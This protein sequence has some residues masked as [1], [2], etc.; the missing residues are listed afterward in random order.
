MARKLSFEWCE[1][2]DLLA[3]DILLE[4]PRVIPAS[5]NAAMAHLDKDGFIDL[6]SLDVQDRSATVW[7]GEE[8]GGWRESEEFRFPED[9]SPQHLEFADLNGDSLLDLLIVGTSEMRVFMNS[10][11]SGF[12]LVSETLPA[13][14]LMTL[15]DFNGD[16]HTDVA[17]LA[18]GGP[19]FNRGEFTTQGISHQAIVFF[20][21]GDGTFT[22]S[23]AY[24][25]GGIRNSVTSGD[26]DG[27]GDVDLFVVNANSDRDL[28]VLHN[29][30]DGTFKGTRNE[31]ML[32]GRQQ[33]GD[34]PNMIV[35][36][37]F[38]S[39]GHLDVALAVEWGGGGSASTTLVTHT[40]GSFSW[41]A[42]CTASE[43]S[44]PSKGPLVVVLLNDGQGGYPKADSYRIGD[45]QPDSLAAN[46]LNGDGHLDLV[47]EV[48][49]SSGHDYVSLLTGNGDGSFEM[50]EQIDLPMHTARRM[51]VA[52]A[53]ADGRLEVAISG[54]L[55][56]HES[57]TGETINGIWVY[58]N[59]TPLTGD[60]NQDGI[61]NFSDFL[62][63]ANNFGRREASYNDGDTNGDGKVSFVDFVLLAQN[64]GRHW[65]IG[66]LS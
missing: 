44:E 26:V 43:C 14:R 41:W 61:V 66:P 64:F 18:H 52:D 4:G 17:L 34:D 28:V 23:D 6:V 37:D 12:Q 62:I 31:Y 21:E 57:P 15:N 8:K 65:Q 20:G 10:E 51:T 30:G 13:S 7:R 1:A 53:N 33:H 63:L 55:Y 60:L 42:A 11:S 22:R 47:A 3:A 39:D 56:G 19:K 27:D 45:G 36:G 59:V 5:N 38:N 9:S 49:N 48:S 50:Q 2:R 40:S 24:A 35:V 25:T 32:P 58:E 54:V 29:D 46:D 16:G